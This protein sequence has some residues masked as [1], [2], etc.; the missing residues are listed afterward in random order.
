MH[1][2]SIAQNIL[3]IIR[4]YVPPDQYTSVKSVRVNVGNLAGVIPESL[5]FCFGAI[6]TATQFHEA[7]LAIARV[8]FTIS[9]RACQRISSNNAGIVQCPVCGGSD[10]TVVSGTELNVSE[11]ELDDKPV[12]AA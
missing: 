7:R 2:L 12:E 9:C 3:E 10:T 1:E 4:Q 8:P 11:I 6:T 5:E